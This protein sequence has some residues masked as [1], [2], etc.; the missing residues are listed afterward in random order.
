MKNLI[1]AALFLLGPNALGAISEPSRSSDIGVAKEYLSNGECKRGTAGWAVYQDAAAASPV[2]GTGGTGAMT[3]IASKTLPLGGTASCLISKDA[4]N[5][6]GHGVSYDFTIDRED[7]AKM[8]N[9][10]VSYETASGTYAAGSDTTDPD[11]NVWIYDKTN[12]TL[13]Q[14]AGYK[15]L[16]GSG[17]MKFQGRFQTSASS[18]SYRLILHEAQ[19]GTSAYG[20]RVQAHVYRAPS[21]NTGTPVTDWVAYTPTIA[22]F[23][24]TATGYWRREGDSMVVRARGASTSSVSGFMTVSIPSGYTI[25]TSKLT[26]SSTIAGTARATITNQYFGTVQIN[27][28]TA[29]QIQNTDGT[30]NAWDATHPATWAN[31]STFDVLFTVPIVGW[32]SNVVMSSETDTRVVAMTVRKGSGSHTTN[33]AVQDITSW[34][35]VT[36]DTHGSFNTT[37]GVYTVPVPGKYEIAANVSFTGNATGKRSFQ[38]VKNGTGVTNSE[39]PA[40]TA[41]NNAM[42]GTIILDCAAGDTL[43]LTAYQ[44]SGGSLTYTADSSYT[45]LSIKRLSGPA[46]IAANETVN[47]VYTN[48]GTQSFSNGV[49]SDV[50]WTTKV[51]DTHGGMNTSTGYYTVPSP[52]TYEVNAQAMFS[53]NGTGARQIYALQSGSAS[54]Q[55]NSPS[56]PANASVNGAVNITAMFKCVAGDVLKV[57]GYQSSGGALTLTGGASSNF[58]TIKRIGN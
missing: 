26:V 9:I 11:L 40:S 17:V 49:T 56:V 14:P 24:G 35:A 19:T 46:S 29:V 20:L 41:Y 12:G 55:Y 13:I 53:A 36:L 30:A 27:N 43:K 45:W 31:G 1:L 38:I 42:P 52:G 21:I 54:V 34:D 32:S 51:T 33:N 48:A 3:V 57:Q 6:Q 16:G 47:A 8:L 25:D 15:L 10:T 7:Q 2:D 23:T 28:T 18:T 58:V 50:V 22:S 44:N 39:F 5:R 4:V 37:T